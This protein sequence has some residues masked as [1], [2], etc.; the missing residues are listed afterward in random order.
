VLAFSRRRSITRPRR[1]KRTDGIPQREEV[2]FQRAFP[3]ILFGHF[4]EEK[5]NRKNNPGERLSRVPLEQNA[6]HPRRPVGV[7]G[8]L[9]ED[10]EE[11]VIENETRRGP[12]P[13]WRAAST[14]S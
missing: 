8:Q 12:R 3:E 11:Q 7:P 1:Y 13:A 2:R 4:A 5:R 6:Q 9:V 10:A 14:S